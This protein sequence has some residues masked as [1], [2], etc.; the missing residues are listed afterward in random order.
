MGEDAACQTCQLNASVFSKSS[1]QQYK[2]TSDAASGNA[3]EY[4]SDVTFDMTSDIS[5]EPAAL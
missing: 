3:S 4:F 2:N 1:S 5:A